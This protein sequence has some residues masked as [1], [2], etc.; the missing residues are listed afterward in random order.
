MKTMRMNSGFILAFALAAAMLIVTGAVDTNFVSSACNTQKIPSGS[1]FNT[2]LRAMLADLRQN[3]AFSGYDYKTSVPE[4]EEHPLPT[5]GRHVSSPSLSLIALLAS[6][7]SS[8]AYFLFATTLSV[9]ACSSSTASS[10][11]SRGASN[12]FFH[13]SYA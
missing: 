13:L 8:A 7:I 4:A 1:P 3:T 9:P 12:P 6:P 5:G 2:N 10:N 11:T